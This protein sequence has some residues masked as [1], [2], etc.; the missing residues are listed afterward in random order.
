MNY[1]SAQ[2]D[3]EI[4]KQGIT[5]DFDGIVTELAVIEGMPVGESM[6]L[7]TLANTEKLKVTISLGKYDLAK[8]KE[9][10]SAEIIILDNSY[11]GKITK[12]DKM[13]IASTN[14]FLQVGAEV[15]IENPD[16]NIVLGL[17]AKVKVLVNTAVD[18]LMIPVAA[19]NADKNGDFVYIMENGS[20]VRKDVVT[21]ISSTE[22]IEVK[23]G[24]NESDKVILSS[25]TGMLEEGM[26]V[27]DM[28]ATMID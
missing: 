21:G 9:G 20:V 11:T 5:A 27:T 28:S 14:G 4:A 22:F 15:E 12:I 7:L 23:E 18:V 3:Y 2:K 8:I 6:Q 17:D 13:A 1:E 26:V 24:L 19:L 10:Q 25:L 16:E